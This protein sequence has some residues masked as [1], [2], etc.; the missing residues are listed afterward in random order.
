MINLIYPN[1]FLFLYDLREGLGEDSQSL[2]ANQK[3]FAAKLPTNIRS[4]LFS[5]D[6]VFESE[7][8]ELLTNRFEGF[9]DSDKPFEG[10]YLPVR[11]NDTYGLLLGCS[12]KEDRT[13][14]SVSCLAQFKDK[15]NEKLNNQ[16]P[17]IGQTWLI[18][19][20][21][22]NQNISP[23]EVAKKC[24]Q[25]LN[26]GL[27]WE[28]DFQGKGSFLGGSI[29]ELSRYQLLMQES[30]QDAKPRTIQEI[31][32]NIHLIIALMPSSDAAKIVWEDFNTELLRLFCYRHKVFWAY[33]QSRYLKQQLKKDFRV[34]NQLVGNI[35]SQ[36][37][38]Q[39][40]KTVVDA[41]N[42]LPKYTTKLNYL[43][44]QIRTIE[45]NAINYSR[46]IGTIGDRLN[47]IQTQNGQNPIAQILPILSWFQSATA[48]SNPTSTNP[49][50]LL[51]QLANLQHPYDLKFLE[52]FSEDVEEKYQ[53]QVQKDY[54]NLSPG[55]QLLQDLINSSRAITEIEQAQRDRTF[56][57]TV[58][59]LGA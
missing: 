37:L 10:Y 6:S 28:R 56:Q 41:H 12:F 50:P 36:N 47:Q 8:L 24:C 52:K 3:N 13:P 33:A 35:Y 15:I 23:E 17:N 51:S 32:E 1:L 5:H 42:I 29:F 22:D 31:Q 54:A 53:L 40:R 59:I 44:A 18:V 26:I 45:I 7:Y 21:M 25:S 16:H 19:T 48:T 11:L 9:T 55:L 49:T 43:D 2:T 4:S 57:D 34:I 38:K 14:H 58:G 20:E 27:K 46:R 39:L 30:T